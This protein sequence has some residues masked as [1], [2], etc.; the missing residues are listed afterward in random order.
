MR[1][2]KK[3]TLGILPTFLCLLSMLVVACGGGSGGG[4]GSNQPTKA[5]D[6]KQVFVSGYD[7]ERVS[8]IKTF[9]PALATDA[10]SLNSIDMVFTGLVQLDDNLAVKG[11]LAQSYAVGPD[12]VTWT[13]KLKPNLTF[14]DGTPLT[15]QDVVYSIDRAL[16]P[17]T[18][19]TVSGSYLNL[20]KDS[21]KL[22]AGKIKTII[23]DSLMAPDPSTV[24]IVTN[25]KA[26]YFLDALTYPTSYVVEKKLIDTYGSKFAD[27]LSEGYGGAG[28]WMVKKYARGQEIDFVPNPHYYGNKPQ[29]KEVIFPFT[30]SEDTAYKAYQTGAVEDALVPTA[31]LASAKQLTNEFHNVPQLY[32]NYYTMN[33]LVKPF[34]NIKVRQAFDL[35]LNK[36]EIVH[37]VYKDTLVASN[38]IVPKGMPGYTANLKAPD[39][40]TST[41]GNPTKAKQLLTEGLQE[42][43]MTIASL[44]PITVYS[45]S[46]GSP[47]VRN[48]FAAEQQM[49]QSALGVTIK[50]QDEDFNKLLSDITNA[51]NNPKGIAFWGIAWIADYPDPQDWTT[52]QFDNGSPN[53]NMNYGQNSGATAAA[54]KTVQQQLEAADANTNA[55]ARIPQYNTAEQQLINDVAWLPVDQVAIQLL[56]KPCVT[57]YTY[58][59]QGLVNPE[60][61]AKVYISTDSNCAN[62]SVH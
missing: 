34:D 60:S 54:Q 20:V 51:T 31:Q 10:A 33:Y 23:G 11:E 35:A 24:V 38:H 8:D 49:W 17:A 25:K 12:G 1:S 32:I 39:G 47:D 42:E 22:L 48:E 53:N 9:D 7:E 41:A 30:K 26:A 62:V 52:L 21:D 18:K 4:T 45:S 2:G 56:L 57:G 36:D 59:A 14:S 6:S 37:A 29:L 44:P 50:F 58:N 55:A 19:S 46:A 3:L 61:W 15:S 5:A 13:F 28:P 27:H 43:G 16:Q 40:T